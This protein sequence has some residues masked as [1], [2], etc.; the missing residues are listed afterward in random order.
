MMPSDG[1]SF[2]I[3][4]ERELRELLL[5]SDVLPLLHGVLAAGASAA[6]LLDG[7]GGELWGVCA[8]GEPGDELCDLPLFLEGEPVGR[9]R[10]RG[11]SGRRGE[12]AAC[13]E[14][15]RV[16][17][18][19][20]LRNSLKRALTTEIH[21]T[22]VNSSY[23]ELLEANAELSRSEA[24]Y[25]ELAGNLEVR[26]TE[27]TAE[28]KR[29]H[30]LLLQ[31]EKMA[32]IGQLA[33]GVAH[34]INNPLGFITSNLHTLQK[35]VG[36]FT[37]MLQFYRDHLELDLPG[38][39]LAAEGEKKWRELKL[40]LALAD[41]GD[42]M[43]QSLSG[44]ERVTRIVADLKG[45]S[46]VDEAG[47]MPVDLNA[48]LERTLSVLSH[49]LGGRAEIVRDLQPLPGIVC[50]PQLPGQA[51]LNLIQ[52]ALIH[53]GAHP[54]INLSSACDGERVRIS[55]AD[56]GPGV[57]AALRSQIF[58]PFYTTRPVGSGTGMGLA[59]VYEAVL[60]IGGTIT[61]ADAPGGGA[62]FII[63]IPLRGEGAHVQIF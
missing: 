61:V 1:L 33:A 6:R 62:D 10:V 48:E 19:T 58:E 50:R 32:A 36:R 26:V 53:G 27:R 51:F 55:I 60:G 38:G 15:V 29:A 20:V 31:Q 8:P 43:N 47:E 57:P 17:L 30:L 39:T 5:E 49:Q 9:I 13:A 54:R 25:R 34:E 63:T 56:D 12:L 28:L 41:V 3:G 2:L 23:R 52:N 7:E 16:A 37:A 59:V 45:F 44:A 21:T 42:L 22:V 11:G 4:E 14:L 40:P 46:H 18:D 24:R 35:Y